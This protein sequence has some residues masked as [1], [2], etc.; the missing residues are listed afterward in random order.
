[1]SKN[2]LICGVGGQ[3]T[4][5]AAKVISQAAVSS[6]QRVLS[7]ETIGMA[8]RGGSVVSHVRIGDDVYSPLIPLACADVIIAF[9]AAEAVRNLPYLKKGGTVIVSRELVQPVTAS[10]SGKYFD[11]SLM[12]DYLKEHARVISV[13]VKEA[14]ERLGSS[15]VANMVLLGSACKSGV[16]NAE[17]LKSALKLLVKP[18]FYELNVKAID[19]SSAL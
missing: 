10:L 18:E 13:D 6:G 15:R 7:A 3:G 9:E 8:Q 11:S 16:V 4:V 2:I 12:T 5:L 17:E 14:C 1:M 19:Y